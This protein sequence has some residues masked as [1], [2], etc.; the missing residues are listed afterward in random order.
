LKG[1]KNKRILLKENRYSI[2]KSFKDMRC[3]W[4]CNN[5]EIILFPYFYFGLHWGKVWIRFNKTKIFRF[6]AEAWLTV[7]DLCVCWDLAIV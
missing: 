7:L 2:F 6:Q 5:K 4:R 3:D 1:I